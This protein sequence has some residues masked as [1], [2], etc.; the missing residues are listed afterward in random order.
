MHEELS[1]RSLRAAP[2]GA[3]GLRRTRRTL[4]LVASTALLSSVPLQAAQVHGVVVD[5]LNR[6]IAGAVVSLVD[7][8]KIVI[9]ARTRTDG[10]YTLSTSNSGRFYVLATG[11]NF[12]Q[13]VTESFY[14][15]S[16][17]SVERNVT[18]QPDTLRQSVVVSATGTPVAQTQLSASVT[19][20]KRTDLQSFLN[21]A[22]ALRQVPGFSVATSG[23]RGGVT[24][25]FIRGGNSDDNKILL[26]GVPMND[27]G[28]TFD[29]ANVAT[30]GIASAEAYRGSDSVVYGT[31][32]GAGVVAFT[33]PRGSTPFP[34][35]FYEGDG[36]N[37]GTYR[38]EVQLGGTRNKLDYY[39]AF[40]DYA[41]ANTIEHNAYHD[42]TSV[43]NLGYALTTATTLRGTVRNS[44]S[45]TG[46]AGQ[47]AFTRTPTDE[48]QGD[49]NL[50]ISATLAHTFSDAW[51]ASATY[52]LAR[53]RERFQ[54]FSATG[55]LDA[56]DGIYLGQNVSVTGANG[57]M[58]AGQTI[59]SYVGSEQYR[60]DLASNRDNLHA[61]TSYTFTPHL[62]GVAAFRYEDERGMT[63][64]VSAYPFSKTPIERQNYDYTLALQGDFKNRLFYTLGGGVEKNGLFGTVGAPHLGASY[65]LV[66]PGAGL[67]HGTRVNFNFSKGYKE[68]TLGQ[69]TGSLLAFLQENGG[70]TL[71]NQYQVQPIGA[72]LTRS[73]DGGIEQSVANERVLLKVSY[74]HNEFG[75]QVES[76]GATAVPQLLPNLT[77]AQQLALEAYLEANNAYGLDLNSLSFRAQGVESEL[78]YSPQKNLFVRGGYTYLDAVVQHSFS[79][80]AL[81]PSIN[82][83]FP[84]VA[85]GNYSPLVGARPFRRP[86]HTGFVSLTYSGSKWSGV[87][88]TTFASRADDT[89]ALGGADASFGNSLLLP[90]RDLDYGYANVNA[91]GT[92]QASTRI[93]IYTQLDNLLSQQHISPVGYLST[94][95]TARG[96]VRITLGRVV[97][98]D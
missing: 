15:G 47:Y 83:A 1:T 11:N 16:L 34:S 55:T 86:P 91:S 28:G 76:V 61:Q 74:F 96:G 92:Y 30:T 64:D 2:G 38:N 90:N 17:E 79:S 57:Y 39:G 8:G 33:T 46:A 48:K 43:T 25:L 13:L 26:D 6:P 82:P 75:N 59:T 52:G 88:S 85:I 70:S 10:T 27:V 73:Y 51:Q 84:T 32:A 18:L 22:D 67:L 93:G 95:M 60:T 14:G 23:E 68:P 56:D 71:V 77:S 45:N 9:S 69:Q 65:Y 31:D 24:S 72:A 66:R 5:L 78:S 44:D 62:T 63:D 20:L 49:Q 54:Q 50:F 21:V 35:L 80:D 3:C 12:R 58:V 29:F 7:N 97:K 94:P 4:L 98:G 37:F 40:S 36:G 41:T 19:D 53:K 87:A 89:T 81:A 42:V